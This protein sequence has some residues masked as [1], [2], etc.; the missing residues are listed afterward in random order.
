MN[1]PVLTFDSPNFRTDSKRRGISIFGTALDTLKRLP[2]FV[3]GIATLHKTIRYYQP[4]IIVNFFDPLV[5]IYKAFSMLRIKMVCI[6]HQYL[7]FH[8]EFPFPK[9]IGMA[10]WALV[11]Y[12]CLCAMGS[13]LRLALSFR[14]MPHLPGRRLIVLPPLL[15]SEI[16]GM[17]PMDDDFILAYVLNDGYANDLADL[18]RR[19]PQVK[20]MG[21]WDRKDAP[22]VMRIQE[23]LVFHQLNDVAFLD[24]MS[25]CKG[26]MSTAGFESVCEAMFLGKPVYMMPTD[27][28]IEQRC[29][30][31][32]ASL[33][34]AGI[35][36]PKFNLDR[37]LDYIP[38]HRANHEAFRAWVDIGE[39]VFPELMQQL[40]SRH[41]A[42]VGANIA[43]HPVL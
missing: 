5:A 21:F 35:W 1:V 43:E 3:R 14:R 10:R 4:D 17:E 12:T 7:V 2:L 25:R 11:C 37:F 26:L 13:D 9:E 33:S 20:I 16:K 28:Q 42:G 38:R 39:E 34:G 8:H 31:I 41:D 19:H 32:D 24:A 27:G 36:G 22:D 15:R 29:N 30:A 18:Q 6:G 23:N 40:V